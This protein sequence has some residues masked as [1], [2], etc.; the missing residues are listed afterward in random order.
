MN[1]TIID[2][3]KG[4]T[5]EQAAWKPA[6]KANP[7]SFIFWHFMRVE[8]DIIQGFQGKPSV[9]ESEKWHA[10]LG[11]EAKDSGVGFDETKVGNIAAL[12]LPK[13]LEYAHHVVKSVEG[14]LESLNEVELDRVHDPNRPR[15]TIATTLRAFVIAHGWWHDGEIKY[16]KGMQ[17]M[18]FPY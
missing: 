8:D 13:L 7:I 12:P 9:W 6:P 2:D 1:S 10:K 15:R 5:P 16:L 3:V 14:Y 18:P 17:G 4:L 11:M